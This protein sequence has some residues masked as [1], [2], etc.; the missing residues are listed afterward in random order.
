MGGWWENEFK[1]TQWRGPFYQCWGNN[2][3]IC[4]G[5]SWINPPEHP[6]STLLYTSQGPYIPPYIVL[7]CLSP[8]QTV[9]PLQVGTVPCLLIHSFNHPL[10]HLII[11]SQACAPGTVPNFGATAMNK[12]EKSLLSWSSHSNG[13]NYKKKCIYIVCQEVISAKKKNAEG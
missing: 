6:H 5:T 8:C 2:L 7:M 1:A 10:I 4:E 9:S 13:G 11:M 3:P 12:T